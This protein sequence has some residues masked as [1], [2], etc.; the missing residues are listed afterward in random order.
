MA[1]DF[2]LQGDLDHFELP[3]YTGG[4]SADRLWEHTCFEV[5]IAVEGQLGYH[6]FNVSPSGDWASYTFKGRREQIAESTLIEP[7]REV[8]RETHRLCVKLG[9]PLA[10]ISPMHPTASLRLGLSAILEDKQGRRSFWALH[11]V[12]GRPDFHAPEAFA[13]RLEAVDPR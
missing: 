2:E 12:P 6:E 13:L 7:M 11:H 5:F 9:L 1:V 10:S 8:Q 4:R 3:T